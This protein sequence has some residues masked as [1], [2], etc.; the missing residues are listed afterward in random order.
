[1]QRDNLADFLEDTIGVISIYGAQRSGEK[2]KIEMYWESNRYHSSIILLNMLDTCI[3]QQLDG[4]EKAF[5][6][7]KYLPIRRF[8]ND[9]SSSRL[10][11]FV[12]IV[13][14]ANVFYMFYYIVLPFREHVNGFYQL[15]P[16]SRFTYWWATFIFDM[17]LHGI[18]CL[19][20]LLI[21]RL[22]MP[23][24]LYKIEDQKLIAWSVFFYGC[25]YLP[26]LYVLGNNFESISTISTYILFMLIVSGKWLI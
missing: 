26:I 14:V 16:M 18:V 13:A 24:E 2:S 11:Y 3:L 23:D 4:Q 5:I 1:M 17:L 8:I 12:V 7:A 15:Q 25:S 6:S 21:Q 19:T 10:E 9:V 22:I 20:L